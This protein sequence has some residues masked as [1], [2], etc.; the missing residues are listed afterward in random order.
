MKLDQ[1]TFIS[2]HKEDFLNWV[3]SRASR[4]DLRMWIQKGM[5]I[6]AFHNWALDYIDTGNHE[7]EGE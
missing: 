7:Y 2:K 5:D 6:Q 4:E 1:A 3:L